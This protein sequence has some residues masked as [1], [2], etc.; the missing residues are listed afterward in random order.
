MAWNLV[1]EGDPARNPEQ[2][3]R[4]DYMKEFC[5][6]LHIQKITCDRRLGQDI[7][8]YL[9]VDSAL[10]RVRFS[11]GEFQ[12]KSFYKTIDKLESILTREVNKAR[13]LQSISYH[14]RLA[15]REYW[16]W[17]LWRVESYINPFDPEDEIE[18]S[19]RYVDW[20]PY[21]YA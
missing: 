14:N 4:Y 19:D 12:K 13:S 11:V 2:K 8:V 10:R 20:A 3:K 9:E 18:K 6:R 7:Y 1:F 5:D 21:K 17:G 16:P 15:I